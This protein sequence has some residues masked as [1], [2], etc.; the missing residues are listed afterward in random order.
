[1]LA[2]FA[3]KVVLI[4]G[5]GLFGLIIAAS[6]L[7]ENKAYWPFAITPLTVTGLGIFFAVATAIGLW[8]LRWLAGHVTGRYV[9]WL[10]LGLA[11]ILRLGWVLVVQ[12]PPTQDYL[13]LLTAARQV[14]D[15]HFAAAQQSP[16]VSFAPYMM[17]FVLYEGAMLKVFGGSLLAL[18]L[19]NVVFSVLTVWIAMRLAKRLFGE[20][21]AGVA[22]LLMA[23]YPP[24]VVLC[25]V[26][27]NDILAILLLLAGIWLFCA[28]QLTWQR[29]LAVGVLLFLGN[30]LRPLASIILIAVIL[31]GLFIALPQQAHRWS[32]VLALVLVPLSFALLSAGSDQLMLATHV[33]SDS[34]LTT[35]TNWKLALGL[36]SASDGKWN[37][38]DHRY[39]AAGKTVAARDQLAGQL[40]H[41]RLAHPAK[42]AKLMVKKFA[43]MWGDIDTSISWGTKHTQ[44]PTLV[45]AGLCVLQKVMYMMMAVLIVV[46]LTRTKRLPDVALLLVIIL[47]GYILVHLGI[48]IQTRYRYFAMPLMM[49]MAAGVWIEQPALRR[50]EA[51]WPE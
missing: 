40:V 44:V 42:V 31:Y 39:V 24:N 2:S 41:E 13:S 3:K 11:A 34:V 9:V 26:L 18:K 7:Y 1:M 17:G 27:T 22:G 14:A 4:I 6:L 47:I 21:A 49:I 15:G 32:Y 8:V 28:S 51:R 46:A 35:S 48:E 37:A 20:R 43:I 25:S 19:L 45:I 36:N 16:Y 29:A 30:L 12:T 23:V 5:T 50:K 10:I 33:T 38:A